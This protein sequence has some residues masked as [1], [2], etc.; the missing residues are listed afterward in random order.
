MDSNVMLI[1]FRMLAYLG[2]TPLDRERIDSVTLLTHH[3]VRNQ[4]LGYLTN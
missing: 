4:P 1:L 2:I 3:K